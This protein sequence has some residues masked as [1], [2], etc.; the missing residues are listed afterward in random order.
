M[1]VIDDIRCG[2][3]VSEAVPCADFMFN[4]S[5]ESR[6]KLF[7]SPVGIYSLLSPRDALR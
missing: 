1:Y 7:N 6:A 4:V 3:L 5:M 2:T